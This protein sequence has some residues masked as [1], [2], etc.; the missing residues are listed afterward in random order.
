MLM[1][2]LIQG[3][4]IDTKHIIFTYFTEPASW[5]INLVFLSCVLPNTDNVFLCLVK[6]GGFLF[7]GIREC[8][9]FKKYVLVLII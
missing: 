5:A 1:N 3:G 4:K 8:K 6:C 7:L 9:A 2:V